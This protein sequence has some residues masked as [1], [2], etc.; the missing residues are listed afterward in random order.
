MRIAVIG[1]GGWGTALAS[2]LAVGGHHV[3]LWVRRPAQYEQLRQHRENSLYLP[4]VSLPQTLSYTT[5]LAEAAAEAEFLVLAVPSHAM[6][7]VTFTLKPSLAR[8]PLL[9]SVSKGIEEE[10]LHTMS[11]VLTDV[12]GDPWRERLAVL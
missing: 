1:A 2:L 5:S 6:R 9:V 7:E 8:S 4:E 11:A 10:T 12:L 3:R